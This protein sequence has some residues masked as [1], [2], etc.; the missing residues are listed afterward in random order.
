MCSQL[1]VEMLL[2]PAPLV[3]VNAC[4]LD[5]TCSTGITRCLK[6][7]AA[8]LPSWTILSDGEATAGQ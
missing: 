5:S 4:S 1:M 2:P 7:S 8:F 3:L 6:V